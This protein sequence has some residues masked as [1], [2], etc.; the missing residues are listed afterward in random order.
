MTHFQLFALLE[1]AG[2][3]PEQAAKR[4]GVSHMTLR[5]WQALP[6]ETVL[7]PKYERA[8][9]PAFDELVAE[10]LAGKGSPAARA[11]TKD[12]RH[13][14][15]TI[16][17]NLGFPGDL[18]EKGLHDRQA[19]LDGLAKVGEDEKRKSD[20]ER[21]KKKITVFGRM[22]K[23]WKER[24]SGLLDVIRSK[25]LMAADKFVAYGALFYLLMPFD[26]IPDP[27][28]VIGLLDDFALLGIALWFYQGGRP[29]HPA[30]K[31]HH[32]S[33]PRPTQEAR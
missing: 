1:K 7:A 8:F 33:K 21:G 27:I 23:E 5:R 25:D 6:G 4:L 26:L 20:V 29:R 32:H 2:L 10:G 12:K 15:Q 30:H 9:R 18:L 14:F 13:S 11:S 17:K 16:L 28:P 31:R 19:I 3:S 22:G 24:T